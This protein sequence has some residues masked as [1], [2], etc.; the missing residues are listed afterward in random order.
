M[1]LNISWVFISILS[2]IVIWIIFIVIFNLI[3]DNSDYNICKRSGYDSSDS[4]LLTRQ[5]YVVCCK[6]IYNER[7]IKE[8]ICEGVKIK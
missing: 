7:N 8:K 3:D 2:F 4:T 6:Y 5:G 1:K